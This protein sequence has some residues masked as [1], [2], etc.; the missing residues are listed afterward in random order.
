MQGSVKKVA[1]TTGGGDCPGL[2]AVIR[3]LTL[4]G[5]LRYGWEF[6]GIEEGYEGIIKYDRVVPLPVERVEKILAQGGTI[7]GTTN[8]GNPFKY[9]NES[10][11][12]NLADLVVRRLR[13]HGVDA[14]VAIGGDGTQSIAYG[15]YEKGLPVVGVPKTIDN[16]LQ[17]TDFTFGFDTAVS[18][19]TE[20]LDRLQTTAE[21]HQRIMVVEV[22]GRHAGWLG[23]YGG[24]AGGADVI[25]IPEIPFDIGKVCEKIKEIEGAGKKYSIVVVSEGATPV[26]GKQVVQSRPGENV[27]LGGIGHMVGEQLALYTGKETRVTVLGHLQRGGS[28]TA[29]DRVLS[30]RYGVEAAQMIARKEFGRMVCLKGSKLET[31]ALKEV[32]ER[33]KFVDPQGEMVRVA[34]SLGVS[35]GD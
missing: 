28:P 21:S 20:A 7:L 3:A 32:A 27:R 22:M 13:Q 35:F 29:H 9:K 18:I 25:L 1:V 26:G 34:K 33:M 19:I 8:R 24:L 2:N 5:S 23:L 16:D 11:E 17:A 10:G 15:L 30:I 14:L 4:T 12:S 31:V 6:V